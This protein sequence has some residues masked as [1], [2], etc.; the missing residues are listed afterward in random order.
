MDK[1]DAKSSV[2]KD[3]ELQ[4]T[5]FKAIRAFSLADPK[6]A[7]VLN[8]KDLQLLRIKDL[9]QKLFDHQMRFSV[10]GITPE[11]WEDTL[12]SLDEHLLAYGWLLNCAPRCAG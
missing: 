8:F 4:K 7:V 9:Q 10:G 6:T 11:R 12:K 1:V 5:A 2:D 3:Q